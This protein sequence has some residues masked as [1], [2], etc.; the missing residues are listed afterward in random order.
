MN[1]LVARYR[2]VQLNFTPDI[3]LVIIEYCDTVG[4]WQKCHNK[5][6]VTISEQFS[7]LLD[8]YF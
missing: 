1:M 7:V 3:R 6:F 8:Q 5:R 4:E 2:K